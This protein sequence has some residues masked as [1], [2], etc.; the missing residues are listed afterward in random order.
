M[1][2]TLLHRKLTL[3]AHARVAALLD[4]LLVNKGV[5]TSMYVHTRIQSKALR[6]VKPDICFENLS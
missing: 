3:F 2:E 4:N 6:K 5:S 1:P